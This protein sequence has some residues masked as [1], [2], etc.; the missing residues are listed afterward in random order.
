[1]FLRNW[2]LFASFW[3]QSENIWSE[4]GIIAVVSE[5]QL[6]CS[7]ER[8]NEQSN[9]V[10]LSSAFLVYL[11]IPPPPALPAT[12]SLGGTLGH[13]RVWSESKHRPGLFGIFHA[14]KLWPDLIISTILS[15]KGE[16]RT[17]KET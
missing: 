15:E 11:S 10:S 3:A 1:M 4:F 17:H 9:I 13:P 5:D 14:D 12:A 16:P 8:A 6:G 2:R 7:R